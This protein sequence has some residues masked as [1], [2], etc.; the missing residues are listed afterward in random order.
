MTRW[1]LALH[2]STPDLGLAVLDAEQPSGTRRHRLFPCGR[3]LTH[4]LIVAVQELLPPEAWSSI[5]RLAVATGPGGFTGTRLTVVM[6]RT[7]AQQLQ[8]PLDGVSSFALMA[9]RLGRAAQIE[10]GVVDVTEPFWIVQDLPRRGRVGGRYRCSV[11]QLAAVELES[12]HLLPDTVEPTPALAMVADVE[13]DVQHLLDLCHEA[14]QQR[15]PADWRTV[16]PLYPTS[17]VGVP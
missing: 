8:C 4:D 17:P 6:A 15:R 2:S 9:S 11:D 12:P 1:L 16:L 14:D 7:L 13:A 3:D 10:G 5:A